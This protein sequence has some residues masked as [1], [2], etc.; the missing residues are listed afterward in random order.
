MIIPRTFQRIINYLGQVTRADVILI[1]GIVLLSLLILMASKFGK[2][3]GSLVEISVRGKVYMK[4]SLNQDAIV[5]VPGLLGNTVVK[6]SNQRVSI[7]SS[8]CRDKIC[9]HMG[10][11]DAHGGVLVCVPNEVSVR[12]VSD[13]NET[14]DALTR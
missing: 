6:I 7:L 1:G 2:P 13:T 12:V 9:V 3:K 14:F 4:Q 11:I 5:D 8:P 10:T